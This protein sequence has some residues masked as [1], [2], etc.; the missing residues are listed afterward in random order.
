M[1]TNIGQITS[2]SC[3]LSVI[4]QL[5]FNSRSKEKVPFDLWAILDLLNALSNNICFGLFFS[6]NADDLMDQS[7]KEIFNWI[8]V[9]AV[10]VSWMRFLS[11]FLVL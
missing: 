6:L 10:C 2:F 7:K 9:F 3:M 4:C 8:Q 1:Y 5:I 11:F